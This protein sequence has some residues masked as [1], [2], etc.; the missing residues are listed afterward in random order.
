MNKIILCLVFCFT[1][2]IF[3]AEY[4]PNGPPLHVCVGAV[5]LEPNTDKIPQNYY[6]ETNWD[7]NHS[8]HVLATTKEQFDEG[9]K[10]LK[11]EDAANLKFTEK[12]LHVFFFHGK[13]PERIAKFG[14]A[15]QDVQVFGIERQY[16]KGKDFDQVDVHIVSQD[17]GIERSRPE[18]TPGIY[19]SIPFSKLDTEFDGTPPVTKNTVFIL[20]EVQV[21]NQAHEPKQNN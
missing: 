12:T 19:Y 11:K 5:P 7:K 17:V 6:M 14:I 20:H 13:V 16:I 9:V 21:V 2:F 15:P 1:F 8:F 10:Y 4:K 18:H 3:A